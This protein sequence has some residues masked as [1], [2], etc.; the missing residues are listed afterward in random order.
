M[1]LMAEE[2]KKSEKELREKLLAYRILDSRLK[3]LN[4]QREIVASK[5]LEIKTTI[6]SIEEVIKSNDVLFSLGSSA[7]VHGSIKDK[8][9]VIVEIGAGI[10]LEKSVDGAKATLEK[11]I[12][13]LENVFS[14]LEKEIERTSSVLS[15]LELQL[16]GSS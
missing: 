6:A 15:E 7:H 4:Q 9:N 5:I 12:R 10:A 16:I 8:K 2:E 13:E 1:V 14:N 3:S 11:R